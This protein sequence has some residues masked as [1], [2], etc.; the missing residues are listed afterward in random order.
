MKY[1]AQLWLRLSAAGTLARSTRPARIRPWPALRQRSGFVPVADD[2][3]RAPSISPC[4]VARQAQF[5][6]APRWVTRT[7][8]R[9]YRGMRFEPLPGAE[10]QARRGLRALPRTASAF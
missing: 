2:S 9:E 3:C 8:S 5:G 10:A 7:L 1:P 6:D 4:A